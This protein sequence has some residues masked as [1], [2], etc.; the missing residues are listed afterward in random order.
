[1]HVLLCNLSSV[2]VP[3]TDVIDFLVK[4]S[5]SAAREQKGE[6]HWKR[7]MEV[8]LKIIIIRRNLI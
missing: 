1:M 6:I 8:R 7:N 2:V 3:K 5:K 4:V